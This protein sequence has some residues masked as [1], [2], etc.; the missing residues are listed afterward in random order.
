MAGERCR[1]AVKCGMRAIFRSPVTFPALS[2]RCIVAAVA[3]AIALAPAAAM[4]RDYTL[5][6]LRIDHPHARPTPPG[7]RTGGA[8]FTIRNVGKAPDR[9]LRVSSPVAQTV[10]L[11]SMTM[12][13]N[14]MKMRPIPALD[15]PAGSTVTL[16]TGG[17]HVMLT[18][19]RKRLAVGDS[20]P[21]T[22]TFERA[23][24]LDVSASVEAHSVPADVDASAAHRH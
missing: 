11:H 19:L 8:Y 23:G 20:V 17:Y 18:G 5:G 2:L 15:L 4:A 9:L 12:D 13:G 6:D 22:L 1:C 3:L 16:G 14:L 21:L 10:E 24:M 7:A